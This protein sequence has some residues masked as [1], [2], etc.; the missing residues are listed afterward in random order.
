MTPPHKWFYAGSNP[1]SPTKPKTNMPT[2]QGSVSAHNTDQLRSL[3]RVGTKCGH[4]I[5]GLWRSSKPW[6]RVRASLSAPNILGY[7]S[8][9]MSPLQGGGRWFES[10]TEY[11]TQQ[12]CS[13]SLCG[14]SIGLK[15]RGLKFNSSGEHHILIIKELS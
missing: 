7:F 13:S 4:S 5:K 10:N 8:G 11:Q 1:V 14:T 2:D 6:M 9:R 3:L 15:N 12:T